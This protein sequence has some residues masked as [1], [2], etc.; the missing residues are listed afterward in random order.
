MCNIINS[1]FWNR[2]PFGFFADTFKNDPKFLIR[3]VDDLSDQY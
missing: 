3:I 1:V 2:S